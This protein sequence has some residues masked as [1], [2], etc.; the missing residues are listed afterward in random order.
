[1]EVKIESIFKSIFQTQAQIIEKVQEFV[2]SV[3]PRTD[4]SKNAR[5]EMF[6]YVVGMILF[7]WHQRHYNLDSILSGLQKQSITSVH[8]YL[9]SDIEMETKM[10]TNETLD[11]SHSFDPYK[12]A[13]NE[14]QQLSNM[15]PRKC[16]FCHKESIFTYVSAQTRS[17]DEGMT[18]FVTC[19]LCGK[20]QRL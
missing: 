4:E 10:E 18:T 5:Q 9:C 19:S 16:Q 6:E 20:R 15:K 8:S 14:L 3:L 13:T 2:N 11:S 17:A 12:D 1:M 7:L